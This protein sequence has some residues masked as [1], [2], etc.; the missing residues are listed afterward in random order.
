AKSAFTPSMALSCRQA[1]MNGF[2]PL[3]DRHAP[4]PKPSENA[5]TGNCCCNT[6]THPLPIKSRHRLSAHR[7]IQKIAQ[8]KHISML[9]ASSSSGNCCSK[10]I[11]CV[12]FF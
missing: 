10:P 2:T 8:I 3:L 6:K 1:P 5:Q 4:H 9:P 7:S 12:I 11:V